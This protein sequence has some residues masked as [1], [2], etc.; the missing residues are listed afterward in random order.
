MQEQLKESVKAQFGAH[1]ANYV[2][3]EVHAKGS[4]LPLLPTLAGLNGSQLVLDVATAA[5]HTA[6]ALAP[7]AQHVTGLDLTAEMLTHARQQAKVRGIE[8]I[9]FAEGDAERLPFAD[10]AFDVITCRIA[11]HHFPDVAAFCRE[12]G[13]VL[14]PGGRL[15]VI[16]NVAPE[17]E[18]LDRFIN[19]IEQL[20]DPTHVRAHR[21]SEWER[22]IASAGLAFHVAHQFLTPMDREDWLARVSAPPAV[23]D[24]IRG[25]L[26]EA[27]PEARERFAIT[28]TH[29]SLHKAILIGHKA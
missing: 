3:S 7:H 21:I 25:R 16:D 5:G 27:T 26:A 10:S 6:F 28:T 11:A 23:A 18:E 29:F 22:L 9:A 1:A 17:E 15:L 2:N 13:R 20:R 14:R 19:S 12:A 4:D 8:N 24:E